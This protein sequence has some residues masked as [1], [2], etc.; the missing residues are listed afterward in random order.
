MRTRSKPAM[1][2]LALGFLAL[3]ALADWQTA[4]VGLGNGI[5]SIAVDPVR[6]LI[7]TA[8]SSSGRVSVVNGRTNAVQVWTV[9]AGPNCLAVNPITGKL[10]VATNS[11][12][13]VDTVM[14]VDSLGAVTAKL[15][16]KNHPKSMVFDAD[17][18]FL[19]VANYGSDTVSIFRNEVLLRH[20]RVK[21]RPRAMV[22]DPVQHYVWVSYELSD[23]VTVIRHSGEITNTLWSGK[24]AYGMA[25]CASVN[26]LYVANTDDDSVTVFDCWG[27]VKEAKLYVGDYPTSVVCDPAAKRAFVANMNSGT[28]TAVNCSTN[29]SA[30]QALVKPY[31]NQIAINPVTRKLYVGNDNAIPVLMIL[32]WRSGVIRD[33][34]LLSHAPG[35]MAL[36]PA[37]NNV[38]AI[39]ECGATVNDSLAVI[40]GSD[41]DTTITVA[42]SG[43]QFT[44]VNPISGD[45]FLSNSSSDNVTVIKANGDTLTIAVG[46]DPRMIAINPL[47]NKVFVCN[48]AG[49]SVSVIN[50]ATYAVERT[51]PVD[52]LP[53]VIAVNPLT[54]Y[55]YVNSFFASANR[56]KVID[57][58]DWD[59]TS[60]L[61]GSKPF[62]IAVNPAT[63]R[64]YVGNDVSNTVTVIDGA[65]NAPVAT[66]SSIS[67]P[68]KIDVNPVTNKIYVVSLATAGKVTVIDGATNTTTPV[69]IGNWPSGVAVNRANNRI[70][71]TNYNDST[72]TE[73]DGATN[74]TSTI[75]V[76]VH[77]EW[78]AADPVTGKVFVSNSD[79]NSLSIIDCASRSVKTL[80]VPAGPRQ[81]T[82]NPAS[83]KVYLACYAAG[84]VVV[85]DQTV[86][87]DTKVNTKN[88]QSTNIWAYITATNGQSRSYTTINHWAPKKTTLKKG[89]FSLASSG[90]Y[91]KFQANVYG[92]TDSSLTWGTGNNWG[93]DT[94]CYGENIMRCFGL[95]TQA[96]GSNNLGAGTPFAGS[97]L[98]SVL[99]RIDYDGPAVAW[100]D[101]L[102]D[103]ND[104]TDGYGPYTVRAVITDFSGVDTAVLGHH[105]ASTSMPNIPMIRAL[106][107]TF[108]GVIPAITVPAES[109]WTAQ[110]SVHAR[111]HAHGANST[112]VGNTVFVWRL[113]NLSNL[114]GVSG[115]P[116][117]PALPRTFAL[118]AAYPN[119][120]K[121]QT[122][123]KYQLPKASDVQLQVYNVSGQLVKRFDEGT[124]PPGYHSVSWNTAG[125]PAG[126]YF[127]RLKAGEFQ[128]TRKLIIIR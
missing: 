83:G 105:V 34:L 106:A 115:N 125:Q 67:R 44:A 22:L 70:Y 4:T 56:V 75:K 28:V 100:W 40:D 18:N 51:I 20:V 109:T 63:N 33:S 62:S 58:K 24:R 1:L 128:S 90:S 16:V 43:T 61:V 15:E 68:Y 91:W 14:V 96:G 116:T 47:T 110:Y 7:F 50:G 38:Y 93:A 8:D 86:E 54:N 124:R 84:R 5:K 9:G 111:D 71:V 48:F 13:T 35:R 52:T 98:N 39:L 121:G 10:Y 3:P 55:I 36:N 126:V 99:Y 30:G 88:D 57:G 122:T 59:T 37:T 49:K 74:G 46:D 89:V 53:N 6:N 60:V 79:G 45:A 66:I 104:P 27:Y 102:P 120:S 118:R 64:I 94:S 112:G 85:L 103:D 97:V 127:Y 25:V 107:D 73:I 21:D 82:V 78:I 119:P 123:I 11:S 77:P 76:G 108:T 65:H 12:S 32:D 31:P 23:S 87:Q 42:K 69:T 29:T 95:E 72:V 17:S 2:L 80:A 26:R 92:A 19:Y 41:F 81:V 113:F 101:S 117:D 114:T